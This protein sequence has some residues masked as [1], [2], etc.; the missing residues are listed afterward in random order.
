[1]PDEVR[2]PGHEEPF[3]EIDTPGK[4]S[5]LYSVGYILVI[6]LSI[7]VCGFFVYYKFHTDS[8]AADK[9]STLESLI[10]TIQ[11]KN[12]IEIEKKV[13]DIDSAARILS[14]EKKSKYLFKLFID[15]LKIKI[16]NDVKLNNL[17][18]DSQGTVTMDGESKSYRAVADLALA[19]ESSSK[20]D[21]VEIA[22]LSLSADEDDGNQVTFSLT[23]DL[24][25]W[26]S[27]VTDE[28]VVENLDN[29]NGGE[30]E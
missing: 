5:G 2:N 30:S 27:A 28:E 15:E 8:V 18:I 4:S 14:A 3:L 6:I 22:G 10:S 24:V 29:E 16:T 7:L 9:Q 1:M 19:L 21:N 23:A 13:N 17:A 11:S 20:I 26:D 25:D 12:N